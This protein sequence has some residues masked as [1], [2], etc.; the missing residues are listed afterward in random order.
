MY[1]K[2]QYPLRVEPE[3]FAVIEERAEAT[4]VSINEWLNRAIAFALNHKGQTL[5]TI[6]TEEWTL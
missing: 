5:K 6:R 4:G 2:R 3:I 1:T